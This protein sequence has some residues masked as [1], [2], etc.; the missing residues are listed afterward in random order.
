MRVAE[1]VLGILLNG[2]LSC[3]GPSSPDPVTLRADG[4]RPRLDAGL[5]RP[6]FSYCPG[7]T[8]PP[9]AGPLCTSSWFC[10]GLNQTYCKPAIPQSCDDAGAEGCTS[11]DCDSAADCECGSCVDRICQPRPGICTPR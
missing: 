5:E 4:G 10:R 7:V 8:L 1:S 2:Y 9:D 3:S 6:E 11:S